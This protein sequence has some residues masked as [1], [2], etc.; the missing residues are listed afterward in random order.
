MVRSSPREATQIPP[1]RCSTAPI[2]VTKKPY[3]HIRR[4]CFLAPMFVGLFPE[5]IQD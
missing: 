5:P 1:E 2:T 3:R 4:L